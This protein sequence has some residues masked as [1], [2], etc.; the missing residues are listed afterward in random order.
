M[1]ANELTRRREGNGTERETA[2]VHP[3]PEPNECTTTLN[4]DGVSVVG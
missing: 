4:W 1:S 2:S 3:D